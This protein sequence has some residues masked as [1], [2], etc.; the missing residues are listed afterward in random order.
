MKPQEVRDM[1]AEE[2]ERK[3]LELKDNLFKLKIKL[4]TKQL[5]NTAQISIIK[6]DISRL[7]TILREK[8]HGKEAAANVGKK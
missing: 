6:K 4:E 3:I 8:K 1:T 7:T 2:I 5:E